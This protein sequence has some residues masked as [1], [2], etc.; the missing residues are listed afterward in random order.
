MKWKQSTSILCSSLS[1]F[2]LWMWV[3][4]C[5][6]LL[7][8]WCLCH[9]NPWTVSQKNIQTNKQQN[10]FLHLVAWIWAFYHRNCDRGQVFW[11]E[12]VNLKEIGDIWDT[13][14]EGEMWIFNINW[15]HG[16]ICDLSLLRSLSHMNQENLVNCGCQ[17]LPDAYWILNWSLGELFAFWDFTMQ[18]SECQI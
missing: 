11:L 12:T 13:V 1:V 16:Y 4:S 3:T 7:L 9:D 6:K 17:G 15:Y 18:Q 2:W 8:P 5:L 10:I 14:T